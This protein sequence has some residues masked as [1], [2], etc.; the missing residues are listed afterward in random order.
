MTPKLRFEAISKSFPGVNALS[1]VS[2]DVAPGE[3]HGLLGENGAGKSTLLRILSGVFRP[4]SGSMFVDGENVSFRKPMEARGAGIAMI[5]Q[6][7]QQV[8]HLSVAQNMFLGHPLTTVGGLFVSRGEQERRAAEAL[9]MIEPGIDP[10]APISSLKVAQ[11]QIVEIARALLDRARIIAMDEPTSSLTPSEFERLAEVITKLS[12]SGVSIIYVSHKMDE[13]FR[14]CQRASVMR[15]GKLIGAVDVQT[16]SHQDVITM[17]VG[18]ELMQEQHVSHA[19]ATVKLEARGL[20]SL[21]KIRDASFKLHRGEVLGIAGLVGSGRT[22]LLRLLAGADRLTAGTIDIDGKTV[23]LRNPRDAISAG[24]GLV[25]EE[26]KREGIIPVRSVTINMALASLESFSK[27]GII[28]GGKLRNT[29]QDLL[30]RVNL[31][32]FQLDRP[33]R[34]FS[35]GNQQKAIIARWLASKSQILLFDEPTRGIDVGAKAEIYHLIEALAADGHS[36]VVVSSELPEVIRLSDRVLVMR[37]GQIAAEI[38]RADL[39]ESA[40]V[41]HAIPGANTGRTPA[42]AA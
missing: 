7:L 24:I 41:A 8:P 14:I 29:A 2:F 21:T 3:I 27:A 26:R 32:P 40:I 20:S 23:N 18:R 10:A 11:R 39:T 22:E 38:A 12:A 35:G 9:S 1:D 30:R 17:M 36:I 5:H 28:Q 37:D 13:V 33:I 34:L 19:T 42:P 4:T 15:D 16:A 25:P 6:E 31:R